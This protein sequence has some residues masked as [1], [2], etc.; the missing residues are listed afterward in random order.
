MEGHGGYRL[1]GL[2]DGGKVAGAGGQPDYAVDNAVRLAHGCTDDEAALGHPQG[3]PR[4]G[5]DVCMYQ[6][7]YTCE[8]W[9]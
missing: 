2:Q 3:P 7:L 6:S 4:P 5:A 1:C 8:A 9:L